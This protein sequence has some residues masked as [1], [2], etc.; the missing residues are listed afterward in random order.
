MLDEVLGERQYLRSDCPGLS[1]GTPLATQQ[2]WA[3]TQAVELGVTQT[4]EAGDIP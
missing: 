3:P 1:F 2:A 4:A